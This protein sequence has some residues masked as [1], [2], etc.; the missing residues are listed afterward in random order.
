MVDPKRKVKKST[1]RKRT[2]AKRKSTKSKMSPSQLQVM[3]DS[4]VKFRGPSKWQKQALSQREVNLISYYPKFLIFGDVGTGKTHNISSAFQQSEFSGKRM[5]INSFKPM[6][7]IDCNRS[8]NLIANKDFEDGYMKGDVI[9]INPYVKQIEKEVDGK[10]VIVEVPITDRIEKVKAV[11]NL[12]K[13]CRSF[14]DGSLAIDGFDV[15]E[16]DCMV[17]VNQKFNMIEKDDGSL[18]KKGYD[19]KTNTPTEKRVNGILQFQYGPRNEKVRAILSDLSKLTIPVILTAHPQEKYENNEPTGII[20]SNLRS[21]V[22]DDMDCIIQFKNFDKITQKKV[23]GATVIVNEDMRKLMVKKNRFQKKG[24]PDAR[25][26]E[27]ECFEFTDVFEILAE[28]L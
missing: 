15:I 14:S 8:A 21:E 27:K 3:K 18:W 11:W 19:E 20:T 28:G 26:I 2:P 24:S 10:S 17:Y 12:I 22:E 25:I 9:I 7:I 16:K 5:H 6:R 1:N 23:N 4:A 13:E